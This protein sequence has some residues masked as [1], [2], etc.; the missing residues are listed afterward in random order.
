MRDDRNDWLAW[1]VIAVILGIGMGY[2]WSYYAHKGAYERGFVDGFH[3]SLQ[4]E[5]WMGGLNND[6]C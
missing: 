3:K 2:T 6:R 1:M 4:G 5:E